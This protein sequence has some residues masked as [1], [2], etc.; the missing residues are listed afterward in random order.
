LSQ[1]TSPWASVWTV[2]ADELFELR[3]PEAGTGYIHNR[4]TSVRTLQQHR[5]REEAVAARE[6]R[7]RELG[8][9]ETPVQPEPTPASITSSDSGYPTRGTPC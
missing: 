5:E 8:Y 9:E 3:L 4:Q 6:Q 7:L 2:A 1:A